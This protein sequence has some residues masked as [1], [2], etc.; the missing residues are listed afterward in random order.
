MVK[1]YIARIKATHVQGTDFSFFCTVSMGDHHLGAY[2]VFVSKSAATA[3]F[4]VT[5]QD[6]VIV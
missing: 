4:P 6:V 2:D 5:V 3:A 1:E